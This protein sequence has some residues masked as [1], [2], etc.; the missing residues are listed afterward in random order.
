[1]ESQHRKSFLIDF[2]L[3]NFRV[4]TVSLTNNYLELFEEDVFKDM[5][6]QMA[7]VYPIVGHLLVDGSMF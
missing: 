2:C 3:G 6:E 7:W 5:L 1:M 4:A